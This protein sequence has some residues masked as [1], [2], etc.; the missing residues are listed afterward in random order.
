M[1]S[2]VDSSAAINK[3][4]QMKL[5]GEVFLPRGIYKVNN[6]IKVRCGIILTGELGMYDNSERNATI[7]VPGTDGDFMNGG[8]AKYFV[9]VNVKV[10]DDAHHTFDDI[11]LG[12]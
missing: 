6:T 5:T 9:R 4:I 1:Q 8:S 10:R 3:A 11:I 7:L 2:G 12:K